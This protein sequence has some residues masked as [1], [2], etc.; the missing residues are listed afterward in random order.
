MGREPPSRQAVFPAKAKIGRFRAFKNQ[1]LKGDKCSLQLVE[2]KEP[3]A[4]SP[5]KQKSTE[6]LPPR[7]TLLDDEVPTVEEFITYDFKAE[8]RNHKLSRLA[9]GE[10]LF[11]FFTAIV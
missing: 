10:F 6:K 7:R 5:T 4:V 9:P 11:L 2:K 3:K 1:Q 8:R